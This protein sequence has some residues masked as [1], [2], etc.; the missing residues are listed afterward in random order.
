MNDTTST[1]PGPDLT[2]GVSISR[3]P[4]GSILQG[5]AH[6]EPVVLAR[7]GE[8][9]F[10]VGAFCSHYGAPLADGLLVGDTLRCPWHHAC[11]NLHTGE[12]LRAPALDAI[13]CWY[14]EQRDGIVYV[15]ESLP[16]AG[17]PLAAAAS[18]MPGSIVIVGGGAAGN[19]A[20]EMLRREGYSGRLTMLSADAS[21]P[22][23]R[24][25]LSKGYLA[26]TAPSESN[27]LRSLEFYREQH[28]DL[29]LNARVAR[30]ETARREVT[31]TDGTRHGYDALLLA[32]GAEPARLDVPGSDLPHVHYLRTLSDAEALVSKAMVSQQAVV[33]GAS[34]IGLEVTASLRARNIGVHVVA[35][36]AVPMERILGADVGTFIRRLHE[37]NGVTFHLGTTV[38][39]IDERGVTL[40]TGERLAADLVVVGIGVRPSISLAE[41]AGLAIDRGIVVDEHLETS[42]PGVFAAGDIARWPDRLTGE[43]IR[44]EHWVV[45]ERQGQTAARNILG[46]RERFGAVPF[47]WTEQYDFSLAYVGHAERFDEAELEGQLDAVTRDCRITYRRAGRKLAVAFVHRDLEGLRTEVEFEMA[48][49]GDPHEEKIQDRRS[50]DVELGSRTRPRDDHQSAHRRC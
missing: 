32:T 19:A 6:G 49:R 38:A 7:R 31:L 5:H 1:L 42:T 36:D 18:G 11:F 30:I 40:E 16:L 44:V 39:S 45:A 20:A 24:P 4:D 15:G 12:A 21:I 14:V 41:D 26:G 46:R 28:I 3:I 2:K 43:R 48:M 13:S 9:L 29:L 34:F 33:I 35:P 50:R 25:N 22:C 8:Q 27:P 10:A 47:F 17:P 37:R 23:D